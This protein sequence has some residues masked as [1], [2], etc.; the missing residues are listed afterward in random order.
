[1]S[2][3]SNHGS[4]AYSLK[5]A[6]TQYIR[7][8]KELYGGLTPTQT[9]NQ[10]PPSRNTKVFNLAMVMEEQVERGQ[11][12][13]TFVRMTITGKL[14][15]ILHV[16]YPIKLNSIFKGVE[17]SKRKVV[18]MEGAPGCGKSTI[19]ISISQQWGKGYLFMEYKAVILVQLRDPVVQKAK[20]ILDLIPTSKDVSIAQHAEIEM[21]SNDFQDVLF[22]LDGWD[23]LP[24]SLR[25]NPESIFLMLIQEDLAKRNG[26]WKSAVIVTSRPIAS[27]KLQKIVS[28][29]VEILGFTP[30]QLTD[31]FS[32]CLEGDAEAVKILQ[33]SIEENPAIASICYIPLNASILVHLFNNHQCNHLPTSQYGVFSLLIC[34][35]ISRHLKEHTVHME[36]EQLV[37][38]DVIKEPFK[39]LCELAY[40][41]VLNNV[42]T[43]SS[44][45]DNINTLGLLQGVESFVRYSEKVMSY[46]FIHL[47]IQDL[48]AAFFM[49]RW[50]EP[51]KQVDKF[52]EL[53]DHPR[54]S[55]VF[56]FYAAITKLKTIGIKD[57]I[58]RVVQHCAEPN[59]D[60]EAKV[61]LISLFHCLYEAQDPSL[62]EFIIQYLQHGLNLGHIT[63]SPV[64]CLSIGFFLSSA[65]NMTHGVNEFRANLFNCNIGDVGCK[66][67]VKGFQK[68]LDDSEATTLKTMLRLNLSWNGIHEEGS[69]ELCRLFQSECISTLDLNGNEEL[70][71]EGALHIAKQLPYNSSLKELSLY[72][73]G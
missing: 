53:F 33:E 59:P 5:D 56:R 60:D 32:D 55:A 16:K 25:A 45:P 23:E 9:S 50:L 35:C 2:M 6:E 20:S 57:V 11:I 24:S 22:I 61:L 31:Y 37:E 65:C 69:I 70:S 64:D 17:S 67:L 40:E 1:M 42:I 58:A 48:L 19:S 13:D 51:S 27:G 43:F 10:W 34:T 49:V 72:T 18:L 4:V 29:Q 26:L 44:L 68:C 63:L 3:A 14:D 36:L 15:D 39:F 28:A 41:G 7:E 47:S 66:Y 12:K 54:F 30:K 46:N 21:R 71:N 73:C 8:L 38:I 62:Y 52:N